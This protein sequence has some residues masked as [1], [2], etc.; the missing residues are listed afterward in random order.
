MV[1]FS[2]TL[3]WFWYHF[4]RF[5]ET[6]YWSLMISRPMFLLWAWSLKKKKQFGNARLDLVTVSF[7]AQCDERTKF[8]MDFH[9]FS[10]NGFIIDVVF[11]IF[12]GP[13][14]SKSPPWPSCVCVLGFFFPAQSRLWLREY[15]LVLFFMYFFL[16]IFFMDFFLLNFGHRRVQRSPTRTAGREK[17]LPHRT[18][19]RC[20][21]FFLKNIYLSMNAFF[22]ITEIEK[23]GFTAL[24]TVLIPSAG[25]AVF[26][27]LFGAHLW[28]FIHRVFLY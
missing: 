18:E 9:E 21:F 12:M 14:N 7:P 3:R 27:F 15:L 19:W 4:I 25:L 26:V 16:W 22:Y 24:T 8:A 20:R 6:V 10:W 1:V 13:D 11:F 5:D 2:V 28:P 23:K 17:A